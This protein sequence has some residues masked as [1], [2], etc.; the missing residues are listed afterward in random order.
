[1][2]SLDLLCCPDCR[3]DLNSLERCDA[4]GIVFGGSAPPRLFPQ[5]AIRSVSFQFT[6]ERSFRSHG[7]NS[8]FAYP[9]RCGAAGSP[10]HLDLAHLDVIEGLPAGAS[11][12][13]IG[14]GGGQMRDWVSGKGMSYIGVDI[15][16][17]RVSALLMEHGGPDILCDAHFM[18]FRNERFDLVYSAAV[19]EHLACPYLVAQEVARVLKPGGFYLGNVSL[20]E[21]WHDDSYFH[22]T[23]LGVYEN[24]VQAGLTPI[25]IWPGKGYS[26]FRAIMS[27]GNKVT[28]PITLLGDLVY[29]AYR[30][31]NK[32][33]NV[34]K[35]RAGWS[36]DLIEDSARV[37]GATDWIAK[38]PN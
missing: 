4:C 11:I 2:I 33:R 6:A 26:G 3:A 31:G 27:M 12:L 23:P 34:A 10:Y 1:M 19:T 28:K 36:V 17:D 24:I 16:T 18:P 20:L 30:S 5:N 13:E 7:F 9:K 15:A 14:C 29:F 37:A 21:P 38:K 8:S 22:M 25:N 35:G 32:L